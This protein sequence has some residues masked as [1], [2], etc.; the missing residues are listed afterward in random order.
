MR[1]LGPVT[2]DTGDFSGE[3]KDANDLRAAAGVRLLNSLTLSVHDESRE[4]TVT[5]AEPDGWKA[6]SGRV[7]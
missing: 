5:I 1:K 3:I 4:M 2:A 6:G 7:G